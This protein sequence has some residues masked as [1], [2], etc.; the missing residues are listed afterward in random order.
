MLCEGA[1]DRPVFR[2]L[3]TDAGEHDM[4]AAIDFVGGWPNL[5]IEEQP[6]RWLDGCR[7]AVII[8]DGDVERRGAL[9]LECFTLLHS[10]RR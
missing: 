6:E 10:E 9:Y 2:K 7:E 1:T 5:L 3:L 8:M 4:A